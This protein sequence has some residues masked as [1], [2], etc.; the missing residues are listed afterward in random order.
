MEL[1]GFNELF[2]ASVRG[3]LAERL[4]LRSEAVTSFLLDHPPLQ[5]SFRY[6]AKNL[7]LKIAGL[8]LDEKGEL[9]R[10]ELELLR[11]LLEGERF[12]L[13]PGREGDVFIYDHLRGCL[14]LLAERDEVWNWIKKFSP[15]LCHKKAEEI[16]R[17]TL[18]PESIS[19]VQTV[20]VRKAVLAAWLTL[21]RQTT[22]S[23]FAT[24][25]AILIQQ[26]DPV[27]FFK[28][29][30]DLLSMG[31]MKRTVGGKQ[32]SVPLS[33]NPGSGDLQ[34]AAPFWEHSFGLKRALEAVGV[35]EVVKE[36]GMQ[37][38]EKVIRLSLLQSIGLTEEDLRDEEHLSRI[39]MTPLIARQSAVFYQKPSERAQKVAEWKKKWAAAC[40]AFQA[41]AD[42]FLLRAWEYTIASFCDVKTEFARWNL[43]VGLGIHPDHKGGIGE[44][45]Y[46]WV[47]GQLQAANGEIERLGREYEQ[48][49]GAIQ[50][51]EVMIEGAVSEARRHQLKA[52]WMAHNLNANSL[53][54]ARNK[55]VEK[56]KNMAGFFSSLMEQYDQKL[57]EYFQELFDPAIKGEEGHLYDDSLAGF[58]LVY[59][60]GRSDA[61]Q[62]TPIYD[63][64]G[65]IN[66]LR[67]FFSQMENELEVPESIGKDFLSLTTT[68]L[69]QFIQTSEFL[70]AALRRSQEMGRR[71]PWDYISGGT[72][73]SLLQT[74]NQ[75]NHPFF[76]SKF[77][78]HSEKEL[79]YFLMQQKKGTPLLIHSPTHA[80][81]FYPEILSVESEKWVQ[82][83]QDA[84]RKCKWDEQMQEH[85]AHR[86]SERL[87]EEE[88]ALFIHLFRQ[89]DPSQS[90]EF[91]RKDLIEALGPRIRNAAALVDSV[92]YE[93]TPLLTSDQANK[94]VEEI[95]R[96][97]GRNG[98]EKL[99]GA[100]W[101]S[102]DVIQ[103]VKAILLQQ[104]GTAFHSVDWDQKIVEAMERIGI[105]PRPLLFADTNWS[106]WL[107]GFVVNPATEQLELWRLNRTATQGFPMTDWKEFLSPTN[108]SAWVILS[109][110]EEYIP[111]I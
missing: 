99:E 87:P 68:A 74:Y 15:P 66:A 28:D 12:V 5:D 31:Q 39:Q 21:L 95:L 58:R 33:L 43:F 13:G 27:S 49:V 54:E 55:A 53:L 29:L 48:E 44:F 36:E 70:N 105:R 19:K 104:M 88:R 14:A 37:T 22:G 63:S 18:W 52:D 72:L 35:N 46:Q 25:P 20:H 81:I 110:P 51:L 3:P 2:V 45:L 47:D 17:N 26:R 34:R 107:F 106:N 77:V 65:Y 61:S 56:A 109:K 7:G 4:D 32:Y 10:G 96:L 69:I 73:Q 71:S 86:I 50:A 9:N 60:H 91:F 16:I 23:C 102:Y 84:V 67:D 82:Q 6:R 62:W 59:K 93:Q 103:Q 111:S 24:A 76:E 97:L 80:F 79:L 57:Q 40:T 83:N 11:R 30:Y 1:V 89:K 41:I 92:L 78:P 94:A 38:P 85:L 42:C 100:F 90:K 64:E 101:G 75:R 8:L 98:G 108:T